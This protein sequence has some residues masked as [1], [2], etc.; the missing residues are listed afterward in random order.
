VQRSKYDIVQ[1]TAL[2]FHVSVSKIVFRDYVF[3]LW[4]RNVD[5]EC[6]TTTLSFPLPLSTLLSSFSSSSS[7]PPDLVSQFIG[8]ILLKTLA[9][10]FAGIIL[11]AI[12]LTKLP[13]LNLLSP[14][15]IFQLSA[16]SITN[17]YFLPS[18]SRIEA[19]RRCREVFWLCPVYRHKVS[20][21]F[22]SFLPLE[23]TGEEIEMGMG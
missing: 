15:A 13:V 1:L 14:I 8:G 19:R 23:R 7:C 18:V 12:L 21:L 2:F 5:E 6:V 9:T 10:S 3:L 20:T 11:F 16:L 4:G 22:P 17:T